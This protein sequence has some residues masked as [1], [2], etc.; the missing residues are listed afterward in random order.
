MEEE[1]KTRRK[2]SDKLTK[3]DV[4][5]AYMIVA[6][7]FV[8]NDWKVDEQTRNKIFINKIQSCINALKVR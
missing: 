1:K 4:E 8:E 6:R 2:K 7:D 5:A 3:K